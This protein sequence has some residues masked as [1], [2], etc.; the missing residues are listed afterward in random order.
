[1]LGGSVNFWVTDR[2]DNYGA[3]HFAVAVSTNSNTDIND[4]TTVQEWTLLS[5]SGRT[6]NTRTIGNGIWYE[7]TADLSAFSGMGYV[8]FHHFNCY[9]QWLLCI[10]DITIEEG[11]VIM[12]N[13]SISKTYIQ[14]E[15]CTVVAT[16]NMG[17][18]F[19]NWTENGEMVS[20][21]ANYTF[22]VNANRTL[23]ANFTLQG[24]TINVSASPSNGGNISGSGNYNYGQSCTVHAT[25]NM[26]YTFSNWTEN[27]EMVSTD[28]NYTF[29][30]NADRTLVANFVVSGDDDHAY[31]DLGLPSG[32]LW[33]TCNVGAETPEEYGDYFAWGET[34]PK[35]TYNWSTYQYCLGSYTT[36]TKYSFNSSYGWVDY[37]A[38]LLPEDD[39]AT[40]NWG[41]DWRMPTYREWQELYQH[42][43]YAWTTQNGVN[44]HLYTASNG[45]S[46]FLPAAGYRYGNSLYNASSDGYYW[47]S[48]LD[49]DTPYRAWHYY[50]SHLENYYISLYYV[51]RDHGQSVRPVRSSGQNNVP[52]GAINGKFT[53]NADGDQV[54][55]SQGNL[56]YQAS[57]NTWRFAENQYDYVGDGNS[58]ASSSYSGWI[59]SFGWGT[60]GYTHGAVCYQP[61]STSH[62]NSD[63]YAY[64]ISGYNLYD[65]TGQADWG[66][67]PISNGGNAANQWRTLTQPEWTYVFKTRSTT[68]G[69]RYAKAN[70]NNVN[71]VI[72]LPDNWNASTY[73]L[74]NTNNVDASFS[75]NT[76]SDAQWMT[77]ENAGAVFLPAAGQLFGT[78]VI[79]VGSIGYYW[80]ASSASSGHAYGMNFSV[81]DLSTGSYDNK[82]THQSVRLVRVA[83][84]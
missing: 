40:A 79:G 28:A 62:Q 24:F 47:S 84:N 15:S 36:M 70:V 21:D 81:S 48:S 35:D 69:I 32:L 11:G 66:Y 38:T 16:P 13:G 37:L 77:L 34:Q 49:T 30:V 17:Y 80:S 23:V 56:Q 52:T 9:N 78:L 73:S 60:S 3:E 18:T 82:W 19:T 31:V 76:I 43:E 2:S 27:G 75:S 10:D 33:A 61:W 12:N 65:Q 6:G 51:S 5:K 7:Y 42:T 83:E 74:S 4:F 58:N 20:T 59:D 63:Y 8:A 50:F 54:C 67:N 55:F 41:N 53:I 57:T 25:A 14:G 39:V 45:N 71:G 68:L 72:L 46:L 29:S 44:G 1:M 22:S 26:G 64:G